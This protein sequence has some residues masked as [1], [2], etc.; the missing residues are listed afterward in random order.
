M[1]TQQTH[2]AEQARLVLAGLG[3]A[4]YQTRTGLGYSLRD[5]AG[6]TGLGHMTISRVEAGAEF[7]S[8]TADALLRWLV[9][10]EAEL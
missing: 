8:D 7:T 3:H 9:E 2:P 6:A 4:R 10:Q 5:V 1:S